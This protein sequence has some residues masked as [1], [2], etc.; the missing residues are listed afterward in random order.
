M[1]VLLHAWPAVMTA[2]IAAAYCSCDKRKLPPCSFREGHRLRW[3]K[4]DL[5]KHIAERAGYSPQAGRDEW[6][7]A[8]E[9]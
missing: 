3:V 4:A 6:M 5:D 1:T 9:Q 2:D 8:L 7:D